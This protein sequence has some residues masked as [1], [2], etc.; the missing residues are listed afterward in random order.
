MLMGIVFGYA[1]GLAAC[2]DNGAPA[3]GPDAADDAPLDGPEE[4]AQG[5]CRDQADCEFNQSNCYL[6]GQPIGC[7]ICVTIE[8]DCAGDQGC[9]PAGTGQICEPVACA[10]DAATICTAGCG[11]TGCDEGETCNGTTARCEAAACDDAAPCPAS[12][13]CSAGHCERTTCSDDV[14]C[15]G[16][17]CV[18][19]SCFAVPG[20]CSLPP[21]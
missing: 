9:D 13:T 3:G 12:F 8:S 1:L 2:G 16:G 18:K 7:G 4:L 11:E 19:G 10:C 5:Q 6:P 20:V 17:Y 15:Q 21:P 14:P